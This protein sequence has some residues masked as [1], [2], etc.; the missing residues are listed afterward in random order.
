MKVFLAG[1]TGATGSV[2]IPIAEAAGIDLV[3]HV[4]P[5][6]A[7]KT[8]LARDARARVFDLGNAQE[9]DLALRGCDA[10]VS[11]IG[12]MRS[13]FGEGDTYASSDV[14]TTRQLV[15]AAKAA[16][17]DRFVLLSSLGAGGGGAYLKA[18]GDCEQI[19]RDSGLAWTIVRPSIL[20]TPPN[21]PTSPHGTRSAPPGLGALLGAVGCIPGLRGWADDTKPIPL[22]VVARAFVHA[23]E[24]PMT[25]HVLAGRELWKLGS[26]AVSQHSGGTALLRG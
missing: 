17:I 26:T 15:D 7:C 8:A 20:V 24:R 10:V 16:K 4:R 2:F 18:K 11:M 19:V 3:F 25:G 1:A 13:R 23:L 21:A 5:Q 22:D 12:T 14:G 6:S 9:L